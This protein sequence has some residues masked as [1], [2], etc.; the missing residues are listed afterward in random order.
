MTDNCFGG[1]HLRPIALVSTGADGYREVLPIK[2]LCVSFGFK[3]T[4]A[5]LPPI[6][7]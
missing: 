1:G 2:L 3:R 4:T 5:I 7:K 6:P